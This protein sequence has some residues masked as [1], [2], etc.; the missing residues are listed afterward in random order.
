MSQFPE[1]FTNRKPIEL[2]YGTDDRAVFN[3]FNAVYAWMSTA[4]AVTAASAWLTSQNFELVKVLYTRGISIAIMLGLVAL[5][6]VIRPVAY[7][8]SA[9][10]ATVLFLIYAGLVGMA[11]SGI[12]VVYK[13]SSIG[14][15]FVVTAGMF[16]GMSVFGFI[17]KRN[18]TTIGSL[19]M[20]AFWGIFLAAIVN[21]FLG[22]SGLSWLIS[23]IGVFVFTGLMAYDTQKLRTLANET[24]NNADMAARVAII[25]SLELY[26]DFIN[27]FLSLLR[28]L[29]SRK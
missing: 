9:A 25:G 27:L 24:G 13:L 7:R 17:T 21:I 12:F 29:G 4:L 15:V 26:L 19:C 16:G 10:A 1:S 6:L 20:M 5:V 14:G 18:L 11:I 2:E 3:F 28:L 22:S 8:I 23:F